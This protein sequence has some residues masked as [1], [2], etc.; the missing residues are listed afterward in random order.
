MGCLYASKNRFRGV[1][2]N[3]AIFYGTRG[4]LEG[5]SNETALSLIIPA[6]ARIVLDEPV[7]FVMLIFRPFAQGTILSIFLDAI[8]VR[9]PQRYLR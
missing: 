1:A 7:A 4:S 6:R 8:S 2:A 3:C 9:P 5:T